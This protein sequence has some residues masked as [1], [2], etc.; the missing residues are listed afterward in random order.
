MRVQV[1]VHLLWLLNLDSLFSTGLCRANSHALVQ[2]SS[3][4]S[5]NQ[6]AALGR[7]L[8]QHQ[9]STAAAQAAYTSAPIA[10]Q[11]SVLPACPSQNSHQ[12]FSTRAAPH[13]IDWCAMQV[14]RDAL[15]PYISKVT[16]ESILFIGKAMRVLKQ[17]AGSKRPAGAGTFHAFTADSHTRPRTSR[18]CPWAAQMGRAQR[19]LLSNHAC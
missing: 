14:A 8:P 3:A 17:S 10:L 5:F 9:H 19:A 7:P 18:T 2:L 1:L 12:G 16:A 11:D 15:P 4:M 13:Q 6:I